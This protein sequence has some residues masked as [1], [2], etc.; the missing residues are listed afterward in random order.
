MTEAEL[1]NRPTPEL[2]AELVHRFYA[3]VRKDAVL[4]P[5]FEAKLAGRWDHHLSKMIDFWSS[6][7]MQTGTYFGKPHVAHSGLGLTTGHF[8]RWL[9]LFDATVDVCCTGYAADLFHDRAR[10]I[11]D[12]LQIGLNIGPK[13]LHFPVAEN[14]QTPR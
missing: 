3:T 8:S 2:V 6:V 1:P 5:I 12:S 4:G 11:A 14:P 7:T 9:D 10:R 13:A